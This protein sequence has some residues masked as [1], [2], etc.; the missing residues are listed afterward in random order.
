VVGP[1][2]RA[3]LEAPDL[4]GLRKEMCDAVHARLYPYDLPLR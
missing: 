1:E 4:T 2:L 3:N